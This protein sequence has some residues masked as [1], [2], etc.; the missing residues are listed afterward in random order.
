MGDILIVRDLFDDISQYHEVP[1]SHRKVQYCSTIVQYCLFI[2][3]YLFSLRVTS[4]RY[5]PRVKHPLS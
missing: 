3:D 4:L 5:V 2:T 1:F